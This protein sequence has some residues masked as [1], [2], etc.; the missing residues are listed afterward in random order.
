MNKIIIL[1]LPRCGEC[2]GNVILLNKAGRKREYKHGIFLEIPE[3]F[4]IPTCSQCGEESMVPEISDE[5]DKL[6][7][8]IYIKKGQS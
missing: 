5:L 1:N 7:D 4:G 2:G 3:D 6:L 8:E